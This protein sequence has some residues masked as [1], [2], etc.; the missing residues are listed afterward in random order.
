MGAVELNSVQFWAPPIK[1]KER[2]ALFH[3]TSKSACTTTSQNQPVLHNTPARIFNDP[4]DQ[5]TSAAALAQ[6]QPNDA[7][8]K[9]QGN[10]RE[11]SRDEL[12]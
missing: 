12:V 5:S 10:T 9:A 11:N 4:G 8:A 7:A 1:T 6:H 3:S 2:L